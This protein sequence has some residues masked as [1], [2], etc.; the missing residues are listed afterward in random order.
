METII[1]HPESTDKLRAVKAVLKALN[2]AFETKVEKPYSP[3][4]IRKI[5][6]SQED[7]EKGRVH[8]ISLDEIW[9]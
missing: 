4:F 6:R 2:V 7:I 5:E 1:A 8:K 3:E 9:K